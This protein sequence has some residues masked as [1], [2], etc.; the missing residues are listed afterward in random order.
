[1]DEMATAERRELI[2]V[3]QAMEPV[4]GEFRDETGAGDGEEQPPQG[5]A[6]NRYKHDR[7]PFCCELTAT[8]AKDVAQR[9]AETVQR[10]ADEEQNSERDQIKSWHRIFSIEN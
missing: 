7:A 9:P 3:Q 2:A 5:N 4:A 10:G 8:E 6:E 1:M